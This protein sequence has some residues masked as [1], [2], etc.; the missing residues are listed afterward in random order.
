MD[1]SKIMMPS[2][3]ECKTVLEFIEALNKHAVIFESDAENQESIVFGSCIKAVM[4][5]SKSVIE[6]ENQIKS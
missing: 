4:G 5:Y 3:S 6:K 1:R 2:L